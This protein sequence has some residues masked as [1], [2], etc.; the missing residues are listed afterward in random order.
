MRD[1]TDNLSKNICNRRV[2]ACVSEGEGDCASAVD[3]ALGETYGLPNIRRVSQT[4][5]AAHSLLTVKPLGAES[6]WAGRW[7]KWSEFCQMTT[8][9]VS[10]PC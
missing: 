3:S 1:Q 8:A 4:E 7:R 2:C 10:E 5:A 6:F 9:A